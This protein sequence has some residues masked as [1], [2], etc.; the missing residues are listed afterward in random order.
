MANETSYSW[1][2]ASTST[3][4]SNEYGRINFDSTVDK[5]ETLENGDLV[6][7]KG[8]NSLTVTGY[9]D[10]ETK[11]IKNDSAELNLN[12]PTDSVNRLTLDLNNN[13]IT[14]SYGDTPD[15]LSI[16]NLDKLVQFS[17]I[18]DGKLAYKFYINDKLANLNPNVTSGAV[19]IEE[20]LFDTNGGDN[21]TLAE[22]PED[23]H[24]AQYY[25]TEGDDTLNITG[26]YGDP[27]SDVKINL[28]S[29]IKTINI[30]NEAGDNHVSASIGVSGVNNT[31]KT[32]INIDRID[33]Y[34]TLYSTKNKNETL[35][36]QGYIEGVGNRNLSINLK[37]LE[38]NKLYINDKVVDYVNDESASRDDSASENGKIYYAT[39]A[40]N[41]TIKSGVKDD[42][43]L[44]WGSEENT[45]VDNGG[46][47][48]IKTNTGVGN[49]TVGSNEDATKYVNKITTG[50]A[51]DVITLKNDTNI[52]STGR[53]NDTINIKGGINTVNAGADND[54]INIEG[55]T[56]T[57]VI[58]YT[59]S[60]KA[61][62]DVIN[63]ASANDTLKFVEGD[64]G[65]NFTDLTFAKSGDDLTITTTDGS[66][67]TVKDFFTS[68]SK[69][70]SIV[71]KEQTDAHSL[72]SDATIN[73]T[74]A[75]GETYNSTDYK[76]IITVTGK[77]T[78]VDLKDEDTIKFAS[79]AELT[80]TGDEKDLTISDGT[81]SVTVSDY[82][83]SDDSAF[84]L[85]IGDGEAFGID[86][87]PH[88]IIERNITISSDY[89][90]TDYKENITV[91]GAAAISGIKSDDSV[92]FGSEAELKY[93]TIDK[94]DLVISDDK[95]N[96]TVTVSDYLNNQEESNFSIVQGETSK[97][98][99]DL[100][101]MTFTWKITPNG[102]DENHGYT[103]TKYNE[104]IEGDKYA[105]VYTA[106]TADGGA[107]GHD[108]LVKFDNKDSIQFSQIGMQYG[109]FDSSTGKVHINVYASTKFD[110]LTFTRSDDALIISKD[111]NNDITID[112]FFTTKNALDKVVTYKGET[113]MDL[114][115]AEINSTFN[116]A[117]AGLSLQTN[118]IK[119]DATVNVDLSSESPYVGTA[120]NEKVTV[121]GTGKVKGEVSGLSKAD[122][123]VLGEDVISYAKDGNKLTINGNNKTIE[124][125]DFFK[126]GGDFTFFVHENDE[127]ATVIK[128][129]NIDVAMA[130]K[131][132]SYKGSALNEVISSTENNET[133]NM[134]TGKDTIKFDLSKGIGEDVITANKGEKLNL[135]FFETVITD[136]VS[137]EVPIVIKPEN[138]SIVGKDLVLTFDD[139]PATEETP[140]IKNKVT[141][142][143]AASKDL[144]A[145]I[146]VN[147]TDIYKDPEFTIFTFYEDSVNKK[148][149]ITGTA[150]SDEINVQNYE[151][152]NGVNGVKI[153]SGSGS[154]QITGSYYND[155]INA[156]SLAGQSAT[157]T[158]YG[159]SNKITTGKGNDVVTTMNYSSNNIN[160]GAGNNTVTLNS[161]GTNKVSAGAGNDTIYADQGTNTIKAGNGNNVIGVGGTATWIESE[162]KYKFEANQQ[163]ASS[164]NKITT[165]KGADSIGIFGGNNTI[166][167]G[168]GSDVVSLY[169]GSN[170]VTSKSGKKDKATFNIAGGEYNKVTSG[171][172]VDIFNITGGDR[173][174]IN[175]GAGND[176]FYI[177]GGSRNV[178][179]G[180]KGNDI[181]DLSNFSASANNDSIIVTDTAGS[182][183]FK[184]AD[185][186]NLF[187]DVK[188]NKNY[189]KNGKYTVGKEFFFEGT[190]GTGTSATNYEIDVIAKNSKSMTDIRVGDNKYALNVDGLAQ[191]VASWLGST[192]NIYGFNSA[193]D[194]L[195]AESALGVD[196]NNGSLTSVF[197][198]GS[199]SCYAPMQV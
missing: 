49:I 105:N 72:L 136:N 138:Y 193:L 84:K 178:I 86:T 149:A 12:Y 63:G 40:K 68:E 39:Q 116:P 51:N 54:T 97:R 50:G 167:T 94:K 170:I 137:S 55:G 162:N 62:S 133:F 71:T 181:Y 143:N 198:A 139:T 32:N 142:K 104:V 196:N 131:A 29:G 76:E 103:S 26:E 132:T 151:S 48:I 95:N 146:F 154:D 5:V 67:T 21:I 187:F 125:T 58:A 117:N 16:A 24:Y 163:P 109:G 108:T 183:T 156:K 42:V 1:D 100:D 3:I 89:V 81:N 119:K 64:Y 88:S 14:N 9:Y 22:L 15:S 173:N 44:A 31:T 46:N 185:R 114:T 113:S 2:G 78:I 28:G 195:K 129:Q 126:K 147:G 112:N 66:I 111:A 90:A 134:G 182:N 41:T 10:E 59:L 157:I 73:V 77:A 153:N 85:Q 171:S 189:A 75:D 93:S 179:N 23:K 180:G 61:G 175:S 43:I 172:G 123:V 110:D 92:V 13:T 169:G 98:A 184:F 18:I 197:A 20:F 128:D 37:D 152:P 83:E 65:S 118:S 33:D 155:T 177:T 191:S 69:I 52:V 107:I 79:E 161:I 186:F 121:T 60:G 17:K 99:S 124:V 87:V 144:G 57:I 35:N 199:D 38:S 194:V 102:L 70:D 27:N 141:I 140:A 164:V 101:P 158:E 166:N 188:I 80:Y 127:A 8:E 45:I 159:G 192:S 106:G 47:N 11:K 190:S 130:E 30:K 148:G 36:V 82:F 145:D 4:S 34:S 135:Q 19:K 6:I 91:V 176:E 53:G 120:Y 168:A 96:V 74:V 56:N 174:V 165:G 150:V 115:Q 122:T 25:L 7:S 160:V